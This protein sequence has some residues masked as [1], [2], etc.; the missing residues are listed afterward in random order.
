M[1]AQLAAQGGLLLGH[2]PVAMCFAPLSHTTQRPVEA[3]L[4][5]LVFDDPTPLPGAP[6]IGG[7][8]EQVEAALTL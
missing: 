2:R 4:G 5:R 1:P 3:G 7:E 8:A 6:P